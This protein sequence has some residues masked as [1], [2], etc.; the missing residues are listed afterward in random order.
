MNGGALVWAM[1]AAAGC[2]ILGVAAPAA[3]Y[4][5]WPGFLDHV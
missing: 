5:L 2:A 4:L 1:R 3:A